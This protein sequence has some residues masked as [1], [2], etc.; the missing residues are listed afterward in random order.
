L[1]QDALNLDVTSDSIGNLHKTSGMK[2]LVHSKWQPFVIRW[3]ELAGD[4]TGEVNEVWP[5]S[6]EPS[7]DLGMVDA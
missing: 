6:T 3:G 1:I 5:M 4:S 7:A 2:R